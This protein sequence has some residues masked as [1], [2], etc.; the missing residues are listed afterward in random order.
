M[1]ECAFCAIVRNYPHASWDIAQGPDEETRA[2]V[3]YSTE[4]VLA[5]LDRMPMTTCHTLVVPRQHHE[6]LSDVSELNAAELG[7]ALPVVAR[8]VKHVSG[9]DGF[10]VVQNNGHPRT[11]PY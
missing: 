5:F 1:D 3:V 4:H 7:K 2:F 6:L 9:A 10:N 11:V 8:A